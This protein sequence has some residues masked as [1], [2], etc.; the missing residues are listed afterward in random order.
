[1]IKTCE[2]HAAEN[3]KRKT[4]KR[5]K[6]LI[7]LQNECSSAP[8]SLFV[9]RFLVAIERKHEARRRKQLTA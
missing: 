1:M 8:D 3:T 7:H 5:S 2:K 4:R 6:R 9:K